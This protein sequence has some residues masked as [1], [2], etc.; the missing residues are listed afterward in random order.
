MIYCFSSVNELA[1]KISIDFLHFIAET[2]HKKNSLFIAFSGGKTP[3]AF[4]EKIA[5]NQ[6]IHDSNSLWNKVH[7]FW[8]DER[9]VLPNHADSNF[10]MTNKILLRNI[11]LDKSNIHRI[12]GENDPYREA[13]RYSA[14][15]KQYVKLQ[16][17]IP[18][19]DLIFLGIGDDGHTASIFPD[20][21]DLIDTGNI[22]EAVRHP[23]T[24]QFRVTLTGKPILQAKRLT[25]LVTGETKST[26]IRQIMNNEPEALAY[27]A[28]Q[29]H[30]RSNNTDWYIDEAAAK[31]LN[32]VCRGK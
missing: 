2:A 13:I 11:N 1:E 28:A 23:V 16:N 20:R 14:E 3:Q 5:A 12:R 27:P 30:L 25:F 22:Y 9:C 31:H 18:V 24:G 21:L 15:I 19:F 8:V 26:V 17:D 6:D 4:F 10:G 29:I 7:L 32:I